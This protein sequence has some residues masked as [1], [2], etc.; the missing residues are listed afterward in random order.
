[1]VLKSSGKQKPLIDSGDSSGQLRQNT[2]LEVN[3]F[4]QLHRKGLREPSVTGPLVEVAG[5]G[6]AAQTDKCTG[7]LH[8]TLFLIDLISV[9]RKKKKRVIFILL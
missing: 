1:M 6:E 7:Q 8:L 4:M 2:L 5:S 3:N 9:R